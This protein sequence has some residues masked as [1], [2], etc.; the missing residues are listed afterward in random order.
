M[1]T[2][3]NNM[4]KFTKPPTE[5]LIDSLKQY[6]VIVLGERHGV[7]DNLDFLIASLTDLADAGLDYLGMEFGADE[8]QSALDEL[9]TAKEFN[10]KKAN[11]IMFNYNVKWAYQEYLDIYYAVWKINLKRDKKLKILNLSY[12][13][14]WGSFKGVRTPKS[15]E[16]VFNKGNIEYYRYEKIKKE[17]IKKNK[18]IVVLTGTIHA[19]S[20]YEF[21]RYNDSNKQLIYFNTEF[22]TNLLYQHYPDKTY[23][24]C[25]HQYFPDSYTMADNHSPGDGKIEALMLEN[26]NQPLG[27]DLKETPWG[28]IRDNSYYSSGY[29]E[30]K[31]SDVFDGYLFLKPLTKLKGCTVNKKYLDGKDFSQ[32]TANFPDSDWDGIPKTEEEYWKIV[33]RF[34]SIN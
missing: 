1:T 17:V 14:D 32:V 19:Y 6:S 12:R 20:K 9:V 8:D 15:M 34:V 4:E 23:S 11:D 24:I 16:L 10:W 21:P 2:N 29:P 26:N 22:M 27:F 18:K 13:F 28:Q 25:L 3:F 7:K 31:L 30:L 33:E 5:F